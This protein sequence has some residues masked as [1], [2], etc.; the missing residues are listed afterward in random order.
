MIRPAAPTAPPGP[1]TRPDGIPE[2]DIL[3]DGQ[4]LADIL[5][6]AGP[7][8]AP[9]ILA[10][11]KADLDSLATAL[12]P[13]LATADWKAIRGQTHILISIAGTI[14]ALRLH[15]LAIDLNAAAHDAAPDRSTALAVPLLSDLRRLCA[16]LD[17]RLPPA[18]PAA[19]RGQP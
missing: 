14:G 13:A 17:A 8:T 11:M 3:G 10:Q 4:R 2:G 9:R 18:G 1:S 12:G 6:L 16:A 15:R 7:E 5:A 19:D